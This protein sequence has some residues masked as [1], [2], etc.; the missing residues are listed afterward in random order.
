MLF[1]IYT[2]MTSHMQNENLD[3]LINVM[4]PLNNDQS[5]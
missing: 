2:T 4:T 5:K 1:F 3:I